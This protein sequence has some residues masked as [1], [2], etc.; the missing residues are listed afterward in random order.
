MVV[1]TLTDEQLDLSTDS[2]LSELPDDVLSRLEDRGWD[3]EGDPD[4]PVYLP[5]DSANLVYFIRSGRVRLYYPTSERKRITLDFL[6]PGE[7]FGELA[8]VNFETRGEAAETIEESRLTVFP[9]DY[10]RRV[11]E[12]T[13]TLFSEVFDFINLRRWRIQNR[14]KTLV[15]E[16]ADR[17]VAYVLLDLG[18]GLGLRSRKLESSTLQITHQELADMAGLARPTTTKILNQFQDDGIVSLENSGVRI[19]EPI[20]LKRKINYVDAD[21]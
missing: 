10:F 11:M 2:F 5:D 13:P 3:V 6:E 20:E 15:Y 7:L 8:L 12:D 18:D 4:T 21:Y 19:E 1:R 14:L 9:G 17:R 16:N